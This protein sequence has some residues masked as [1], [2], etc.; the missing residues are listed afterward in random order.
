MVEEVTRN[1]FVPRKRKR[2]WLALQ[3]RTE[4][5]C[6]LR[7]RESIEAGSV[8]KRNQRKLSKYKVKYC[9]LKETRVPPWGMCNTIV[10]ERTDWEF[11]RLTVNFSNCSSNAEKTS[12][13]N[14]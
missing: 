4:N 1:I 9:Q 12:T 8:W 5:M 3:M 2:N 10:V 14:D 6:S 11:L 13:P 7:E